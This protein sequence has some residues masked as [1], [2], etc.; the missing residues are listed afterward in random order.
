MKYKGMGD[1]VRVPARVKPEGKPEE[2][3]IYANQD[4]IRM[5]KEAG[6]SGRRTPFD[7][8]RSFV[9]DDGFREKKPKKKKKVSSSDQKMGSFGQ[10]G[11]SDG[12]GGTIG[13]LDGERPP[14][15]YDGDGDKPDPTP[16]RDRDDRPVFNTSN[17]TETRDYK[18]KPLTLEGLWNNRGDLKTY[19]EDFMTKETEEERTVPAGYK[20]AGTKYKVKITTKGE[21]RADNLPT[22]DDNFDTD[23]LFFK[24]QEGNIIGWN[25]K[26][27]DVQ[28]TN[29]DEWH[30]DSTGKYFYVGKDAVAGAGGTGTTTIISPDGK[31]GFAEKK[32]GARTYA[33]LLGFDETLLQKAIDDRAEIMKGVERRQNYY[34]GSYL[35][36][37]NRGPDD[38]NF[39]PT[40]AK[41]RGGMEQDL[42]AKADKY[43]DAYNKLFEDATGYVW[44]EKT[45]EYKKSDKVTEFDRLTGK[46]EDQ[47]DKYST[48][49][50][51][52]FTKYSGLADAQLR[53]AD[54]YTDESARLARLTSGLADDS[55]FFSGLQT[56]IDKIRA[57]QASYRGRVAGLADQGT[58]TPRGRQNL[59][60]AQRADEIERDFS[61]QKKSLN[62][63]LQRRGISPNSPQALK[64][65]RDLNNNSAE[66]KRSARRQ[67]LFDAIS[68]RDAENTQRAN[69]Y[70][71]ASGMTG[72]ELESI[73][74]KAGVRANR[75]AGLR[76]AQIA[77]QSAGSGYY[78]SAKMYQ[79]M[80]D[81]RGRFYGNMADTQGRYYADM[82]NLKQRNLLTQAGLQAQRSAEMFSRGTYFAG[83]GNKL[84]E[85]RLAEAMDRQA[86][87]ENKQIA[88]LSI[89]MSKWSTNKQAE[90]AE[91]IAKLKAQMSSGS[92]SGDKGG[93]LLGTILGGAVGN[94]MFPG[95]PYAVSAGASLG[96]KVFPA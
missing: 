31:G 17:V 53:R 47:F 59:L 52:E 94:W 82:G 20:N 19:L 35:D 91:K 2:E 75:V 58:Q 1:L 54:S 61:S 27:G 87:Q 11:L 12:K 68:M 3:L 86:G 56:D 80:G 6:G 71:Q 36:D 42:Y 37:N 13:P 8:I 51:D 81:T 64:L 63:M 48:M 14:G 72:A 78:D 88:G 15:F 93:S 28:H 49:A 92:G 62:E 69:M 73:G 57:D 30:I 10:G 96:N 33:D 16:T 67:S 26:D 77:N 60:Y 83:L 66:A 50:E 22:I 90:I 32:V 43:G 76:N 46:S 44:D 4:E 95:N 84:N 5:L 40:T 18:G 9:P 25:D 24:D 79:G 65:M 85:T 21:P 7:G 45:G 29:Q 55:D 34:S 70:V 39:D 89:G 41:F 74:Q 38:E 23:S